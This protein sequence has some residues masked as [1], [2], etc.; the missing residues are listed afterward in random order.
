MNKYL[1]NIQKNL[2]SNN[3]RDDITSILHDIW[4][5]CSIEENDDND[6]SYLLPVVQ[7]L[8]QAL[9]EISYVVVTDQ[10]GKLSYA[11][12]QYLSTFYDSDEKI[13]NRDY[14]E[15]LRSFTEE[16]Y[17]EDLSDAMD[18]QI[19]L[20]V[21]GERGRKNDYPITLETSV[22]PVIHPNKGVVAYLILHQDVTPLAEA[23]ETIK[24]L[25]SMDVLT[26]L[27]T[28]KQFE[29]DLKKTVLDATKPVFKVGVLFVDLDRFKYYND[30]LG[31][32][33]GDMLIKE[34]ARHM[35]MFEDGKQQVYRYGGDE[36]AIIVDNFSNDRVLEQL[37]EKLLKLFEYPFIV[38]GSELFITASIGFSIFPETG[39]TAD[40]LVQQAEM[41]MHV[42]KERGKDDY[43]KYLPTLRTKRDEKLS[44]EKRV[45]V[46]IAQKSFQVYYQP[47]I[48]LREKRVVGL[49]A[50]LRWTDK[51]LGVISPSVFI[52]IAEESGLISSIGDWVLEEACL[53]AKK[54]SEKGFTMRMGINISPIQFQ[55]PD[56]VSKVKSILRD[57]GLNPQLLDLEITENVLLYNREECAKTL[58]RLKELGIQISIDDFGTG[59]SSLSYLRQFPI[60]TLKIDKSFILEVLDN[61]NDQAIV[62]S[63]I[64][65]A[66]NMN[67]RVIAEGV[68]S[69]E[70]IPF[71]NDRECD[72]MQGFLY[73]KPLP[74]NEVTSFV[75]KTEPSIVF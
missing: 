22:F 5:N 25:V 34:I 51:K 60:D 75:A 23:E 57:T 35:K 41:A 38:Q 1:N 12:T 33:T 46:A 9:E 49:E 47:Q 50:L 65:L 40:D 21:K 43:Q 74:A 64:Q 32:F 56:F 24:K 18:R 45:R 68:E 26:G 10:L 27:K 13:L 73:S 53:Q 39:K 3:A 54:W 70:M 72:E 6:Y 36:F 19:I 16:E 30:T 42:A 61:S 62:T 11:S 31:H 2:L 58:T 14:L 15:I 8:K 20:K 28:R 67:M 44:I 29:N 17:I 69:T 66:H 63:I 71:L 7:V 4:K 52:P 55:R 59:Y 48:D 37:S